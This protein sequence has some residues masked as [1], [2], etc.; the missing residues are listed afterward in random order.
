MHSRGTHACV[1]LNVQKRRT[2]CS[3]RRCARSPCKRCLPPSAR[4]INCASKVEDSCAE[5]KGAGYLVTISSGITMTTLRASSADSRLEPFIQSITCSKLLAAS[6]HWVAKAT[7]D[8][9]SSAPLGLDRY[10]IVAIAQIAL[11][12]HQETKKIN[13]R[14]SGTG[15]LRLRRGRGHNVTPRTSAYLQA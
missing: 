15:Y 14:A 8:K 11:S 9:T 10:A 6:K 1:L 2:W 5:P 4:P 3:S 12:V 13:L 7:S